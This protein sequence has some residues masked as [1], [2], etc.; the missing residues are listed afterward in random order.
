MTPQ[1]VLSFHDLYPKGVLRE[2]GFEEY[3]V[4]IGFFFSELVD[5]NT[6]IYLAEKIVAFPFDLFA[7]RDNQTFFSMLWPAFMILPF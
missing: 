3:E 7:T 5:L 6:I 1:V 4:G 2:D